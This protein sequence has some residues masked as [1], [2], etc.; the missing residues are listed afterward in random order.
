MSSCTGSTL[1]ESLNVQFLLAA[2]FLVMLTPPLHTMEMLLPC[3]TVILNWAYTV[4]SAALPHLS[5]VAPEL[6][7]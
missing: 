1:A 6:C 2:S 4:L 3:Y 5:S 7:G